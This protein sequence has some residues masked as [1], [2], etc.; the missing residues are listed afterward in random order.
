NAGSEGAQGRQGHCGGLAPQGV[1]VVAAAGLALDD[2][3][4]AQESQVSGDTWLVQVQSEGQVADGRLARVE[5]VD[6]THAGL[7]AEQ[8]RKRRHGFLI[9]HGHILHLR[10]VRAEPAPCDLGPDMAPT[11]H[12]LCLDPGNLYARWTVI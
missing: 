9:C 8:P 6:Q 11:G 7:V 10:N 1:D 5:S 2:P 12:L 4:L 3:S